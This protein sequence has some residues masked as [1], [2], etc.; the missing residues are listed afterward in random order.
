MLES[1]IK[2]VKNIND[3]TMNTLQDFN[4]FACAANTTKPY[5]PKNQRKPDRIEKQ[6]ETKKYSK[7]R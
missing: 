1:F 5:Y 6:E 7:R 4:G 2:N 3:Y